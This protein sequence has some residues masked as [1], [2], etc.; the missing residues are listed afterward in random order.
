MLRLE[1]NM[2]QINYTVVSFIL[3][4][5]RSYLFSFSRLHFRVGIDKKAGEVL[6]V[7]FQYR[8]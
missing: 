7:A 3:I 1:N 5:N 2:N 4:T 6:T 8:I